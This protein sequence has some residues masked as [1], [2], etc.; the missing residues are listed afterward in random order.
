[1][2][3]KNQSVTIDGNL[4]IITD[5]IPHPNNPLLFDVDYRLV[6]GHTGFKTVDKNGFCPFENIR[7]IECLSQ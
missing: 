1:M 3:T 2:L 6:N 5:I 7:I 4:A